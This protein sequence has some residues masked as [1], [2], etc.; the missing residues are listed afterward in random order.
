MQMTHWLCVNLMGNK[1]FA[2]GLE[3]WMMS[4]TL[5]VAHLILLSFSSYCHSLL[6]LSL[7]LSLSLFTRVSLTRVFPKFTHSNICNNYN[8]FP[9]MNMWQT[10]ALC[11]SNVHF[12]PSLSLSLSRSLFY[13]FL[14]PFS[15]IP[16]FKYL[17]PVVWVCFDATFFSPLLFNL[18]TSN[19]FISWRR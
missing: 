14:L 11:L 10:L 15:V 7:S 6:S 3:N 19:L 2:L 12:P 8:C 13:F 9:L 16:N 1:H 4:I 5:L 17:L 18:S